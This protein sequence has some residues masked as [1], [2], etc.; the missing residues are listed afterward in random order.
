M[1]LSE[2]VLNVS[3]LSL[4]RGAFMKAIVNRLTV[5]QKRAMEIEI[6]KQI[7]ENLNAMQADLISIVLWQLH[8][9]LRFGKKRLLRFYKEFA[10]S[11]K[12]LA[13]YYDLPDRDQSFICKHHLKAIGVDVD[14][15]TD[16]FSL[17]AR[18]E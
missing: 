4:H 16:A 9:Q 18:I 17:E 1:K 3:K 7:G 11:L 5:N 14:K 8:K 10:P 12:E 2:N 13:E 6:R 15:M